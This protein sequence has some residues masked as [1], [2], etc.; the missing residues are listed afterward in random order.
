MMS[1]EETAPEEPA[2]I[3]DAPQEAA[4]PVM[5]IVFH[6]PDGVA[7]VVVGCP[8]GAIDETGVHLPALEVLQGLVANYVAWQNAQPKPSGLVVP[9]GHSRL[10]VAQ[11][12]D[13]K[14]RSALQQ[15]HPVRRHD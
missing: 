12:N 3:A 6:A 8:L 1:E 15:I 10:S 9:N 7:L 14:L 2:A 13:A 4:A 5:P 11:Q